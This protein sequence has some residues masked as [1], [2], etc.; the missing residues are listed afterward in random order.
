M[1]DRDKLKFF[2]KLKLPIQVPFSG[3]IGGGDR[4]MSFLLSGINSIR[5][6]SAL[7]VLLRSKG[8]LISIAGESLSLAV[9]ENKTV[10]I[11]GKIY[12]MEFIYDKG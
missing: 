11:V 7:S 6:F 12:K 5:E 3:Q 4:C 10:E 1:T 9:Y 2:D 8:F